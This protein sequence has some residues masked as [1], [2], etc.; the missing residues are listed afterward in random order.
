MQSIAVPI[1]LPDRAAIRKLKHSDFVASRARYYGTTPIWPHFIAAIS[2]GVGTFDDW[3]HHKIRERL[4]QISS[5]AGV[6]G[7]PVFDRFRRLEKEYL[8]R[9]IPELAE[10]QPETIPNDLV[11]SHRI[12]SEF[13]E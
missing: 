9:V 8:N 13:C 4:N 12:T 2:R 1:V 7:G 10:A 3:T 6:S 11:D 5:A